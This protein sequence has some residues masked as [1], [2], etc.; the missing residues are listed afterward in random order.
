M[1]NLIATP[2]ERPAHVLPEQ[3]FDFDFFHPQGAEQDTHRAWK[4][5]QDTAPEVFWTPRNGGHWVVTRA[6]QVEAV[7]RQWEIFSHKSVNIPSNKLPSLP[8]E[9]DPPEHTPLRALIS[10]LFA[11][12]TLLDV[13]AR[14]K[15]TTRELID[16]FIADGRCEF[17]GQFARQLPI[18]MFLYLDD[19]PLADAPMLLDMAEI[20]VRS[21]DPEARHLVMVR[22]IEYLGETIAR[23]RAE[24]G[25]DFISRILQGDVDGRKLTDFEAQNLLATLMFGGLDTVASMLGFV[26]QFLAGSAAHRRQLIDNPAI[27]PKAVN[28]LIRRHGLT[29]TARV[30]VQDA[31]MFGVQFR[32]GDRVLVPA[33]LAGL[34]ERLFPDPLEV[35]F[36]RSNASA[37]AAFGNG[38]HRCPGA[39]LARMELKVVLQEWLPRIPDFRIDPED[40]VVL[41]SG[42]VNSVNHLPLVWP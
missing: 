27:I 22:L 18:R 12:S 15:E 34:D 14:A 42:L 24:P 32:S 8:L 37:H 19:P 23:R 29:H 33:S 5:I 11:P 36:A 25:P 31:D 26:M 20:R 21:P 10:P 30:V 41:S 39:N 28:E 35:D 2:A 40:K 38:P 16:G 7:Q 9:T 4:R 13:E 3:V 17:T 1:D 6:A